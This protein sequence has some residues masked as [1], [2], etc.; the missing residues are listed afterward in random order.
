MSISIGI[1]SAPPPERRG[2]DRLI[3]TADAALYRAKNA[4]RN[5]VEFG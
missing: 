3:A 5:R 4:G 2:I 1:A